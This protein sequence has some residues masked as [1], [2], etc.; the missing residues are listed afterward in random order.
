MGLDPD[1]IA[2]VHSLD[3]FIHGANL[4]VG[5]R[6]RDTEI[7]V[8]L[9]LQDLD[10]VLVLLVASLLVL[11]CLVLFSEGLLEMPFGT[12][13]AL[14]LHEVLLFEPS[15]LRVEALVPL[16]QEYRLSL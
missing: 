13:F 6:V 11:N 7:V 8:N 16:L 1:V 10:Q 9:L 3:Q 5:L 2:W 4:G 15:V 12:I 14:Q